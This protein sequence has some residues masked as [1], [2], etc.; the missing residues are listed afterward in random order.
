MTTEDNAVLRASKWCYRGVWGLITRYLRV[1]DEPPQLVGADDQWIQCFRPS[2]GFLKYLKFFF[3]L[4][5]FATD[6]FLTIGWVAVLVALPW[7]G[8]LI[9]P[10]AW[11]VIVLPD[12]VAYVAI[13]LRYDSTWYVLSDR[14]MRIRRGIWTIHE[15]TITYE[16]IQNVSIRQGPLQR[17]FGIADVIV[18]T[19]GGGSCGGKGEG[20]SA[21]GHFGLLEGIDNADEVRQL[22][23][24]KWGQSRS[25]GIG[26][27]HH[28]HTPV[29]RL[30]WTTQQADL[31]EEIRDLAVRLAQ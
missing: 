25:S 28:E 16:N 7:L 29:S 5:L 19:A 10:L 24:A 26:D 6:I 12:I 13:H 23:L 3:W 18:E 22:I 17:H 11:A 1:P 9:A 31:I 4:A 2:E 20:Q 27:D 14:S 15:T 30:G 8:I 21:M